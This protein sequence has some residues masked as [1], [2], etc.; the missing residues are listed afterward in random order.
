[1]NE[2]MQ[3]MRKNKTWELIPTSP[4]KKAIGCVWIYKVKY[5]VDGSVNRY[6]ERLIA[7]GGKDD[8]SADRKPLHAWSRL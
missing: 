3:A 2:E 4:R 8:N 6:K 1:M 7:K 5:N